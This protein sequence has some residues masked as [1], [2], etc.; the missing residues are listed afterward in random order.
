[1]LEQLSFYIK[2]S[3]NDLRVNGRRTFF[4]LLCIAAG[5][6]AI[7]SLQ[8]LAVMIGDTL[9]RN[10]QETNRGDISF[11]VNEGERNSEKAS[12]EQGVQD[13]ILASQKQGIFGQSF[14]TYTLTTEGLQKVQAWLMEQYGDAVRLTYRLDITDIAGVFLGSGSGT[15]ATKTETGDDATQLTAILID[16]TQYPL[17]GTIKTVDGKTLSE[18]LQAP[19]DI[20]FDQKA[21]DNLDVKIGD[22]VRLKDSN[23]DFTVKGIVSTDAEVTD[24]FSGIFNAIFG[25]YYLRQDAVTTF[26]KATP[27]VGKVY[28]KVDDP[29]K[30]AEIGAALSARYPYF[31]IT[32]TDDLRSQNQAISDQLN[33]LVT[34]MGLV[35]LLLG[36]IG[37]VNTMQ[38][39]V[40]RRTVEIAVL[41]TLGLQ[42]NQ[43]TML[44]L[45]EAFIMGIVGSLIGIVL[46]WATTFFI[47]GVAESLVAQPLPFRFA[48]SPVLNGLFVGTL[49]TTIFGFLPTLNAGQVRPGVVL[50]P[51]DMLVP[52]AGCLR[53][54]VAVI[55]MIIA[56]AFV[57]QSIL[58]SFWVALGVTIGTFWAAL[59][60]FVMLTVLI[61]LVGKLLPSFGSIDLKLSLRQMLV[62]R[63]R[64]AMTLLALVVGVFSLSLITLMADSINSLLKGAI[65]S[66]SGGN[67]FIILSNPTALGQTETVLQ[68]SAGVKS[69]RTVRSYTGTLVSVEETDGTT[70]TPEQLKERMKANSTARQMAAAFGGG[71][72]MKDVDL[73]Q[74]YLQSLGALTGR[75][76]DQL[77]EVQI[78]AGRAL[79]AADAG[80]PVMVLQDNEITKSAQLKVG[81][82]LTYQFGTGAN[83]PTQTY[84]IVGIAAQSLFQVSASS[85][86]TVLYDSLPA[87]LQPSS[88]QV[89]VS[90]DDANLKDF[91]RAVSKI[92]GAFV[93]ETAILT[94]LITALLGTFTAFPTMVALLGLIVGGVVIANSVALT[95]MER[96]REI[97]VMKSIGVQRERVLGMILIENGILGLIG[98]LIGVGIGLMSLIS[99]LASGGALPLQAIPFGT[100]LVLMA[101]C[102]IIALIAAVLTAWGA[103]G[104]K[105]LNVLR[106]E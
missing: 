64:N 101:L 97:A 42:A 8:T 94:K 6:A 34:V 96:R 41:K 13:G 1:M 17:Y 49:V 70:L 73:E 18:V 29:S 35:S 85:S 54:V 26:D 99:L 74:Q 62:V 51:N 100:A 90:I 5:V 71:D 105:P 75:Q 15:T 22:Q 106:Y 16:P 36:S 59:L 55:L 82:K 78:K 84:E 21:A 79:T 81:D 30:M 63:N 102:V 33:Q 24:P 104:E 89:F 43:V 61:W 65:N 37:I 58:S 23:A 3:I 10:L 80:K 50:R 45:V 86:Q 92:P 32:T 44:F 76:V 46:G 19:T 52:R 48:L 56:L 14:Q 11:L 68:Q 83:A 27:Q 40:R 60:L 12:L 7:V 53:T 9:N 28:V 47:K 66:A 38:V 95:T 98:G 2:H 4:A 103:S 67:V 39:I 93:L 69:Y 87:T 57:T 25:F 88:V 72:E 91:R 31:D 77:D 20:V